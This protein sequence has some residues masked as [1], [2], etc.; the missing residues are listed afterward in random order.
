MT[1]LERRETGS[2]E[3]APAERAGFTGGLGAVRRALL[4][5]RS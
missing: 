4:H 3:R 1:R 2:R 5:L